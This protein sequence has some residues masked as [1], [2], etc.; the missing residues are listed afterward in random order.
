MTKRSTR[1]GKKST[2]S[3]S[4]TR[5]KFRS[6][7]IAELA[8]AEMRGA[9]TVI[10]V[11]GTGDQPPPGLLKR[12]W[13]HALFGFDV[14]ERGRLA[15][16]FNPIVY[17]EQAV[18][19]VAAGGALAERDEF[20]RDVD[21]LLPRD[22][23]KRQERDTL[24]R[25]AARITAT[26]A[27]DVVDKAVR[28]AIVRRITIPFLR[29]VHEFLFVG[30][31]REAMRDSVRARL[32][33]GGGPFVVI[34]HG[35][36]SVIAYDALSRYAPG[37]ID[38]SLFVSMGSPLGF[39][40][41][42]DHLKI[43]TGQKQLLVP[44][45]VQRWV[46]IT[47]PLDPVCD[48]PVLGH[49]YAARKAMAIEDHLMWNTDSPRDPHSAAGYLQLPEVHGSVRESTDR[50][51]F[52]LIAPSTIASDLVNAL[53]A[54]AP[55]TR[56]PVLIELREEWGLGDIRPADEVRADVVTW[57][58]R[59]LR[60]TRLSLADVNLEVL[61]RYV[62]AHLTR[63]EVER[64]TAEHRLTSV[65]GVLKNSRK[66]A[67][68][69][70]TIHVL[71]VAHA[72]RG[73]DA[74]GAG[75]TWAVLDT[76]ID[77][78]HPHFGYGTSASNIAHVYD[79]TGTGPIVEWDPKKPLTGVDRNGHGSHVA[80][81]I[82]G[83]IPDLGISGIAPAVNL[84][85]Y[86]VLSDDGRGNDAKILKAL[87]HIF[88]I[89]HNAVS[90][91]IH[92]VNLSLGGTLD[93]EVFRGGDTPIGKQLRRLCRQGVVVVVA[94]GSTRFEL[95]L[96]GDIGSSL[97]SSI[98]DPANVEEAIAVGS[99]HK[100]NP[101]KHGV[102]Y[103]SAR[104]PTADGLYKPDLVAP[105]ERIV[106]CRAGVDP[107]KMNRLSL[108]GEMS[109]TSMAAAHV[110]GLIA[111][112]LSVRRDLIGYPDLVKRAL[113]GACND[114]RRDRMLQGAGVPDLMKML[115]AT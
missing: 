32:R 81:I 12:Q 99:V 5:P 93:P 91:V 73:Y 57:I 61:S 27:R 4:S 51:L 101:Q 54:G 115:R 103:F 59:S 18:V 40:E 64:L 2:A 37:E 60:N 72:H 63:A 79:C 100:S 80:G 46:N 20:S 49:A 69:D 13:D 19:P 1:R 7:A 110:S 113:L 14:G 107:K 68:L 35:L 88:A 23:E 75:I 50:D 83:G 90:P 102:S 17:S 74:R 105:G 71:Q 70:Q 42:Q 65:Q 97:D 78:R 106:S 52:Q 94:A 104:G 24:A 16:W 112:F 43:L 111:C 31:R 9:R 15:Y 33:T 3:L 87:D 86:K 28:E 25:I 85:S 108:Y 41:V 39:Q 62:A 92:G 8:S 114:V 96:D 82:G 58:E 10:Y 30:E 109:G 76:G 48:S 45:V 34:G 36:G 22:I 29:A 44:A 66:R 21:S 84:V 6:P 47:D 95:E 89:N 11:H 53:E 98:G 38:V 26:A 55:E 67:L 56:H 77:P